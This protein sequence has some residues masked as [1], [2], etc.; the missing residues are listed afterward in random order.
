MTKSPAFF[1]LPIVLLPFLLRPPR[2]WK[3]TLRDF[4]LWVVSAAI[5]GI[6]VWPPMWF[7]PIRRLHDIW[8]NIFSHVEVPEVY[9]W[10][11]FH[12]PLFLSLL[13]TI[14]LGGIVVYFLLQLWSLVRRR[15]NFSF[16]ITDLFFSG[17]LLFG[18]LLLIAGGDHAR[19]NLPALAFLSI[20][21]AIGWLWLARRLRVL[22]WAAIGGL[23]VLQ[24]A[25]AFPWFPHF[26]SYHNPLL[27]SEE[28]KRLLV[29]IGNGTRLVADYVNS[30]APTV[31]ATNLPGLIQPYLTEDRRE[32]IRRL[33]K[34]GNLKELPEDVAYLV[35]P[36]SFPARVLFDKGAA[37]M[38][39][40]L[41]GRQSVTV[42]KVRDVPLFS[43]TPTR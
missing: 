4:V 1:F 8:N 22:P 40:Q 39:R 14:T 15:W 29:D 7:H 38:L 21:G 43:I 17:G 12:A 10:P 6:A 2:D 26:P 27:R 3:N 35:I 18:I 31:F 37:E 19:K 41:K 28:G 23:L 11:G 30:H 16:L 33:P 9:V 36:E 25:T 42:L 13:S 32:N 24:A 20:P 5:V 34:S